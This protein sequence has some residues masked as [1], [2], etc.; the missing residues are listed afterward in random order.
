MSTIDTT[1]TTSSSNGVTV[2][3]SS[4]GDFVVD[5]TLAAARDKVC[6]ACGA[7]MKTGDT[8]CAACGTKV[9]ASVLDPEQAAVSIEIEVD[10]ADVEDEMICPDCGEAC[11][12]G[13]DVCPNCGA[14]LAGGEMAS[15]LPTW[16]SELAYEGLATS[17]GRY[18]MPGGITNRDLPLTLMCQ[19]VTAEG[20]D[21]A[22]VCGKMTSI[23]REARPD[24]GVGVTAIMA[25]GEFSSKAMG[26]EACQLVE[27]QVLRGVSVDI[28]PTR[29]FLIDGVTLAEVP[30]EDASFEKYANGEYLHGIEGVIMGATLTPF[31]AFAEANVWIRREEAM[32]AS[33]GVVADEAQITPGEFVLN[34]AQAEEIGGEE[35]LLAPDEPAKAERRIVIT[36]SAGTP[37]K[38]VPRS[39][40]ASAAGMAPIRPPKDWF[41]T[42]EPEGKFPLTVMDDG[43]IMGHLATWDQCHHGFADQCM[44]A[45]PSKSGYS[46]FHVGQ[47]IT[48]EGE[49]VDVGRIV[50]GETVNAG[51]AGID[52]DAYNAARYY[53]KTAC[54][55]AFVRA[56]DGEYGIWLSGVVR[57]DCPSE[58]VRDMIAN[59]PSGDW[60]YENGCLELIAALSVPVAGF[61]VPRYEYALVASAEAMEVKT[62]VATG[63]YELE[64]PTYSRAEMRRKELL[65]N[66]AR[67]IGA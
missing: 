60:R 50:V 9:A 17:D 43:R 66:K 3:Y 21:G 67:E 13:S 22:V 2:T 4:T 11:P 34:T 62:L 48:A 10:D 29:Q 63:Y 32:V 58:R 59:P 41:F 54:V 25:S 47:I 64:K 30:E 27:E 24:L 35:M 49:R 44:L 57:S 20:H 45:R 14:D 15:A 5:E 55:G 37:V 56:I 52:L 51:H 65:L 42:P 46:F 7:K 12:M 36:A 40:T 61:P 39:I 26:P 8:V 23:W 38:L 33:G 1:A 19:T 16:E 6:M 28:A 31:A 53:D 18:L